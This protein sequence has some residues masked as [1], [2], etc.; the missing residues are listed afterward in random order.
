[1]ANRAN[2]QSLNR[3]GYVLNNPIR[4]NDPSGHKECESTNCNSGISASAAIK[5]EL[6]KTYKIKIEGSWNQKESINLRDALFKLEKYLGGRDKL[7]NL[8]TA[9]ARNRDATTISILKVPTTTYKTGDPARAAWCNGNTKGNCEA[10]R[11]VYADGMFDTSYQRSG[12]SF[13]KPRKF[14]PE[15]RIQ[16]SMVHEFIHAFADVRPNAV[17]EYAS[18]GLGIEEDMANTVAVYVVS[19]GAPWVGHDNETKFSADAVSYF[20][21]VSYPP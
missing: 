14:S 18:R 21:P 15:E 19:G 5:R 10:N 17:S 6:E 16:H 11:I 3:F 4:Y 7:N 20:V 12:T 1:M 13:L 2:P 8:I 9:A